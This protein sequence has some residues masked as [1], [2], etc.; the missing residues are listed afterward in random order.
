MTRADRRAEG[1]AH[2]SAGVTTAYPPAVSD[3]GPPDPVRLKVGKPADLL[4][5][6]PFLLG[7]HPAESLVALFLRS[8][9][10]LLSARFDLVDGLED[11]VQGLVDQHDPTGLVLVV[12]T[13]D[14]ERGRATLRSHGGRVQGV[15][16][17]DL[18]LVDG[19]RW[20]SL[21]CTSGCCP[22]E[23]SP[24]AP[25]EHPI[26]AEAVWA[27]L[28]AQPDRA[29]VVA[30][31][32]GPSRSRW[33]TLRRRTR[34]I[35][36]RLDRGSPTTRRDALGRAVVSALP[37]VDPDEPSRADHRLDDAACLEL[38]LLVRE[39]LVR[40]VAC[41]LVTRQDAHRHVAL[42][43]EVVG[44]V[45]PELAAAPVCLLGVSAWASGNGTLLNACC[46]RLE[47]VHPTY[48][49]GRLLDDVSR[50]AL[51]PAWWDALADGLRRD[52]G[53]VG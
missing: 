19:E 31:V 45:P 20:W 53:L 11:A 7:F 27:G 41:A 50:R 24:Y 52:L 40:D 32:A 16:V 39:V 12:Y 9:R 6:V 48:P 49:M 2:H 42:W 25:Q 13:A 15:E 8:G 28:V 26:S 35:R 29:S 23:G 46:E 34:P 44:R 22:P 36:A 47:E 1:F 17:V 43:L 30:T 5:T 14:G 51:P 37:R 38:A 21:T 4:A 33:G 10:V 18:L 3:A